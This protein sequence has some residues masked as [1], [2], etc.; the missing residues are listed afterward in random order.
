MKLDEERISYVNDRPGHDFRYATNN[1]YLVSTG[2]QPKYDFN[3][4]LREIIEWYIQNN[5]WWE[6]EYH[7]TVSNRLDRLNLK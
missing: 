7:Q 3:E 2:W 6:S 4:S 1:N 5:D